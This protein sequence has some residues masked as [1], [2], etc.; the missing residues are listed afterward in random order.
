MKV[1]RSAYMPKTAEY[2][3]DAKSKMNST[4]SIDDL[5]KIIAAELSNQPLVGGDSGGGGGKTDYVGQLSQLTMMEQMSEINEGLNTMNLMGQ[6]NYA[7][8]LIGKEVTLLDPED[9]GNKDKNV[10]GIVDRVKFKDGYAM[11][12]VGGKDYPMGAVQEVGKTEDKLSEV[13]EK[14]LELLEGNSDI[15]SR[16]LD[17]RDMP[18]IGETDEVDGRDPIEDDSYLENK[19]NEDK[20]NDPSSRAEVD[21]YKESLNS[22]GMAIYNNLSMRGYSHDVIKQVEPLK[23]LEDLEDL[24]V[25]GVKDE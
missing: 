4:I 2:Q 15:S 12:V 24:K 10:T 3:G 23:D 6:H 9:P 11:L 5:M 18:E 16:F 21:S 13:D 20:T 17:N 22:Q 19:A 1:D 7:F 25:E 8:T 14:L